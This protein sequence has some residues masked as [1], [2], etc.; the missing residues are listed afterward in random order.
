MQYGASNAQNTAWHLLST[1]KPELLVFV[2]F[3]IIA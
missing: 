2:C 3:K 1:N